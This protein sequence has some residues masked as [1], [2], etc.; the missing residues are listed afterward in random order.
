MSVF[1][2]TSETAGVYSRLPT[3]ESELNRNS[4]SRF[5][6]FSN[7]CTAAMNILEAASDWPSASASSS[8][9]EAVSG[10]SRPLPA[11]DRSSVLRYPHIPELG[12]GGS[13]EAS[14]DSAAPILLLV[15]DNPT[16]VFVI[17]EVLARCG[18]DFKLHV[19][20]NGQEALSYLQEIANNEGASCPALVLL[21][22]NLPKVAGLEVLKA[23]RSASRCK[24]VPVIIVTSSMADGDRL[25]AQRL[26]AEAYFQK[27]VDLTAYMELAP[28]IRKVLHVGG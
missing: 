3:M 12:R 23:L 10:W 27:P 8:N 26:G 20:R 17:N 6:A 28:L 13:P 11:V 21:D 25:A 2:P 5:S 7:V 4:P 24:Q 19:A 1:Q 9:T 18:V 14:Q 22:L 16:D 15:E